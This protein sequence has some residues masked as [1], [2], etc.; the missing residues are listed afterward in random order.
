MRCPKCQF[1][2]REEATFCRKCGSTLERDISCPNCET[3]NPPDSRFCEKCG[4]ILKPPKEAPPIDYSQP[5]SYTPKFLADKIL[6]TRSSIEGE[7]K[8][9]TVLFADVANYTSMSEELDPEEVHQIMDGC[10]NILMDEIHRYEGTINQFT[11]D[12]VMA[13]FGAPLAHEDHAQ[14]S[15]HA[16]LSI[17][18]AVAAYEERIKNDFGVSFKMRIGLNSG[19]VVVGSIGD[20]LRMD[21]TAM[22]DT[23]NI[24]ARLESLAQPGA[25]IL[26]ANTHRMARDFFE[27]KPLG[28]LEVKGKAEAQ[29]AYELIRVTEV[30]TRIEAAAAKG[31]T[32][33][34]GRSREMQV[35]KEAYEKVKSWSGQVVGVVG[36]AGVGKS[37]MLLEL[38][39]E[40]P[41]GEYTY[42]EGR[43]LHYGGGMVY[44]PI[45]DILR[46]YLAI[47]EGDRESVIKKKLQGKLLQLNEQFKIHLPPLQELLSLKID[48]EKYPQLDHGQK[49]MR[50]FEGMRDVLVGAS[51]EK[52]LVMAVE[53]LHWI[54]KTSEEFLGYFIDWIANN[55]IL[56]IL[57]YRPE[58]THQWGSKSYYSKIGADQLSAKI[59]G[60]LV[61]VILE[62]GAV[63][64]ELKELILDR[65]SGNPLYVE[66]LTQ[67]LLENGTI[68]KKNHE[69]VLASKPSDIRVPD[70]IQGIIATRIDR[71]EDNLKRIMQIASVI[72]REFAFRILQTI[73]G[74][75]EE[76]KSELLNLQGLEFISEKR[77]FPELEYIF[78]HALTQ[79]VAYSSL[80]QKR[81]KEIH[82]KIGAAIEAL[83]PD[84]IEDYYELLAY[85]YGR[86]DNKDKAFEYLDLANRKVANLNAMEDAMVYF[87]DAMKILDTLPETKTNQERRIILLK[88]QV[89][90][91]QLL[92]KFP[93]Y[94]DLLMRFEPTAIDLE[95]QSLL[96]AYFA[97]IGHC[98][99]WF[100]ELNKGIQ[101]EKKAL[102]L[103]KDTGNLEDAGYAY[104]L[105]QWCYYHKAD[106]GQVLSLK[107]EALQL[108]EQQF[109]LRWYVWTQC[110]VTFAYWKLG[111]WN[112]SIEEGKKALDAA[113]EFGDNSLVS[114]AAMALSVPY[115]Q[116]GELNQGIEYGMMAAKKAP[117]PTDKAWA[118]Q[119]LAFAYCRG[120]KFE[121]A[122]EILEAIL[123][124]F[125][126]MRHPPEEVGI[127]L[128]LGEAYMQAGEYEKANH[129]LKKYI[130]LAERYEVKCFTPYAFR[131]LGEVTLKTDPAQAAEYFEK[132][133]GISQMVKAENELA[134]T[135]AD[136]GRYY[137]QIGDI[138]QAREYL[139]KALKIFERL[140]TLIEPDKIKI[141]LAELLET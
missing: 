115:S 92:G 82:K 136:Y 85:H 44:L 111:C 93:E 127:G 120:G 59:S 97:R 89:I 95:N 15:C 39:N 72:G 117:T 20:D 68:Q 130:E 94:Y 116:K 77:L 129:I 16:A 118:E 9:V 60:E 108:L 49:K 140:G 6:T 46:S 48:D 128:I 63:V 113:E 138:V 38:R 12:G 73:M 110:A 62:N 37:R 104:M 45:L 40:L 55:R 56:M 64:T 70:T 87:D 91:F 90:V 114:F 31:L 133:I 65:A 3:S 11:G 34:V 107:K 139:I 74:M 75:R 123:P 124:V 101:T 105:L 141:E 67:N 57:L 132:S 47:E 42:L 109:N 71:V 18:K 80:L 21:Y 27:F 79:E 134:L 137:K 33:F 135:Y 66:E 36:E 19:P 28:G 23:T 76:L 52:P 83:Y 53:D 125:R 43:C 122:I 100:G 112:K 24:A 103:C 131:I 51:H 96:G 10:F 58:Y 98:E 30:E 102:S 13:L 126:A 32:T 106:F 29:E 81:K 25:T 8:L 69:Y 78:K 26:S 121:K 35:L 86:G 88:N 4:Q 119:V 54:D 14:R 1:E 17:Q 41:T 5:Q 7:R 99:W 50:I 61:Q 84:R 2:N 22:G